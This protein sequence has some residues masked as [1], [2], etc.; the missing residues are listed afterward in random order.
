MPEIRVAWYSEDKRCVYHLCQNCRSNREILSDNL[1]VGTEETIIDEL[2][3]ENPNADEKD[4]LC[5][6]CERLLKNW[7]GVILVIPVD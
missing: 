4:L 3:R 2:L 6:H 5:E 1:V 7:R